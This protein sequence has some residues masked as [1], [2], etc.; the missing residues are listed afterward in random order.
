MKF[1]YAVFTELVPIH[2]GYIG[3]KEYFERSQDSTTLFSHLYIQVPD[4]EIEILGNR[5][6]RY[7]SNILTT[8]NLRVFRQAIINYLVAGSIRSLSNEKENKKYKSSFIIH[9]RM[10]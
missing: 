2:E 1:S 4:D 5:D 7:I 10:L 3:G 8:P 9:P 6:Q